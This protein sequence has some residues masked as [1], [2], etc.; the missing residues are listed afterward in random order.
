MERTSCVTEVVHYHRVS[1]KSI[2]KGSRRRLLS[3]KCL[4]LF[5]TLDILCFVGVTIGVFNRREP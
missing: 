2:A 4:F 1:V 5:H 3:S